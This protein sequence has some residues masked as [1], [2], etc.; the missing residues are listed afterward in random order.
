MNI[1]SDFFIKRQ[2]K[3]LEKQ[4]E[5]ITFE[6]NSIGDGS[7][8]HNPD[9]NGKPLQNYTS[10]LTKEN[11]N[12][13]GKVRSILCTYFS[14]SCAVIELYDY[15]ADSINC[16]K[17]HPLNDLSKK[18][19]EEKIDRELNAIRTAL[20]NKPK[21]MKLSAIDISLTTCKW[22]SGI[23]ITVLL[24][25][26]TIT[27]VSAWKSIDL[28]IENIQLKEKNAEL[29]EIVVEK[30]SIIK[31]LIIKIDSLQINP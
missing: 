23:I 11:C 21:K 26:L 9:S 22:V 8:I 30:D 13:Y 27:S 18:I 15:P 10:K 7:S 12:W 6:N 28:K 3:I 31:T 4:G 5:A 25:L 29:K 17:A 24:A 19:F 14:E 16:N 20:M 1:V 2:L